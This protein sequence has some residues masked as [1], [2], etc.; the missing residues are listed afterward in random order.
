MRRVSVLCIV[1]A[2]ITGAGS[3]GAATPPQTMRSRL[4]GTWE[5]I[6]EEDF[7]VFKMEI[8]SRDEK[9]I[10]AMTAGRASSV[11]LLFR[12]KRIDIR[13]DRVELDATG[14]D[15]P[16]DLRIRGKVK[17]LGSMTPD[18]VIDAKVMLVDDKSRS[19]NEWHVALLNSGGDYLHQLCQLSADATAKIHAA[20]KGGTSPDRRSVR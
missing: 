15:G 10:V 2:L 4:A 18:G 12:I 1:V 7:R 14:V 19:I 8:A 16:D 5:G 20:M 9:S 13:G 11:T 6:V 3:D 17:R